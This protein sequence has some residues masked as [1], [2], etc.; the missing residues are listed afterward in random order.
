MKTMIISE[1]KAKCIA[2]VK[3]VEQ[4]KDPILLTIRGHPVAEVHPVK[5][6]GAKR[7]LGS[8]AGCA[9][10]KEIPIHDDWS[11]DWGN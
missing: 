3:S 10:K 6:D 11:E 8:Q 5:K 2:A 4:D 1:F 9:I 7:I